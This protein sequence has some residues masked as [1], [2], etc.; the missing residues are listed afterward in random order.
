[1]AEK[2]ETTP[3][4]REQEGLHAL[5]KKTDYRSDYAPEVLETFL[6]K[7]PLQFPQSWRLP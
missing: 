5:G 1:M 2:K 7:H 6:N 3:R 4:G